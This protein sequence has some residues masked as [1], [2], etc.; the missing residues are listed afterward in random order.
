M[1]VS[2][3]LVLAKHGYTDTFESLV[4]SSVP[5]CCCN[6]RLVSQQK[7]IMSLYSSVYYQHFAT[8]CSAL[9]VRI[10]QLSTN[11]NSDSTSRGS[12]VNLQTREGRNED[13]KYNIILSGVP[14]DT[15]RAD[16]ILHDKEKVL[17]ALSPLCLYSPFVICFVLWRSWSLRW[18]VFCDVSSL[19]L[20]RYFYSSWFNTFTEAYSPTKHWDLWSHPLFLVISESLCL[21]IHNVLYGQ[22]VN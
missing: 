9:W 21:Y 4:S 1:I 17:G 12:P 20:T 3:V 2:F 13:R 15:H 8:S 22:V 16:M 11:G 10:S 6:C 7:Y 5:F 14:R 18:M 19:K